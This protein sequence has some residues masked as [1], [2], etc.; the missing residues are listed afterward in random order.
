MANGDNIQNSGITN[1][2]SAQGALLPFYRDEQGNQLVAAGLPPFAEL[3]RSGALWQVQDTSATAAVVVR[4][5]TTAGLTLYNNEPTGGK[6]YVLDAVMAF[7]LVSTAAISGYSIWVCV[8]PVGFTKPTADIVAIKSLSGKPSYTGFAV[9]DTA[10]TVADD[11]WFPVGNPALTGGVTTAP[12][13]AQTWEAQGRIVIPPTAAVSMN[14]VATI[15]GLTFTHGF[16]W[17][18]VQQTNG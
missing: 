12:S 1:R 11:G 3:A 15:T 18:E 2:G 8:H 16:R 4:P 7:N 13:G 6:S 10:A 14:V 9:V 17:A 5:S